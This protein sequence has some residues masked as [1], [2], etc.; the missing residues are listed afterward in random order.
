MGSEHVTFEAF[1]LIAAFFGGVI[2]CIVIPLLKYWFRKV[3]YLEQRIKAIE[4]VVKKDI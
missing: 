3:D 4:N 2:V 1:D